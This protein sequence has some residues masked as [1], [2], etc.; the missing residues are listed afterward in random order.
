MWKLQDAVIIGKK[1]CLLFFKVVLM[2][3]A[4]FHW[5]S[6]ISIHYHSLIKQVFSIPKQDLIW[7][8][9]VV[10]CCVGFRFC[11]HKY[12]N[13]LYTVK[14]WENCIHGVM[15]SVLAL[16]V[17]DLGF[18]PVRV[19]PKTIKFGSYC[20]SAKNTVLRRKSKDHWLAIWIMF[21]SWA[22]CLP[23][24]CCFSDLAL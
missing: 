4:I 15:V 22:I 18:K 8:T 6:V 14:Y 20:F 1:K 19:K 24:D 11:C 2:A 23:A 21:P 17:V 5:F 13:H 12:W 3:S 16:S 10:S 7:N 9:S